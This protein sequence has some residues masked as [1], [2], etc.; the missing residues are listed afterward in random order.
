MP[1]QPPTLVDDAGREIG[2]WEGRGDARAKTRFHF[3]TGIT[4]VVP[5]LMCPTGAPM[6]SSSIADGLARYV[7]EEV[8]GDAVALAGRPVALERDRALAV[9]VHRRLVAV[10]VV[11]HGCERLATVGC[12]AGLGALPAM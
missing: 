8:V 2:E 5:W 3:L 6:P 12:R 10:E 4:G 1:T 9:E 11:E 7:G